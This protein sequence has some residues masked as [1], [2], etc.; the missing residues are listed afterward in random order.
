MGRASIDKNILY[1]PGRATQ[2]LLAKQPVKKYSQ[3][4]NTFRHF[5]RCLFVHAVQSIAQQTPS[6]PVGLLE[7]THG[8]VPC[9]CLF[10]FN[11]TTEKLTAARKLLQN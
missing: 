3:T 10:L 8:T 7:L 5:M 9:N 2:A 11:G 4:T 6:P 1:I